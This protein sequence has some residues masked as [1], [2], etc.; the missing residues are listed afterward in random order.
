[1]EVAFETA[2]LFGLVPAD[3]S[4]TLRAAALDAGFRRFDTASS[5]GHGAFEPARVLTAM[6]P[7]PA[8]PSP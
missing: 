3:L 1:M 2:H 5:Y 4:R 8:P 6:G 7:A